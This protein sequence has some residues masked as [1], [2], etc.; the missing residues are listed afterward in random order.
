V[1]GYEPIAIGHD[2]YALQGAFD[3]VVLAVAAENGDVLWRAQLRNAEASAI[4]AAPGLLLTA[5]GGRVIAW[6]SLL[7]PGPRRIALARSTTDLRAGGHVH[8]AGVVGRK[9]RS[10]TRVRIERARLGKSRFRRAGRARLYRDG[11]FRGHRRLFV[12]SRFRS[13]V[14]GVKSRPVGVYA[15][16]RVRLRRARRA[17]ENIRVPIEVRSPKVSVV[18]HTFALYLQRA[19]SRRARLLDVGR[20]DGRRGLA[21]TELVFKPLRR[22]RRRD[23]LHFCIRGQ[24]GLGLGRPLPIVRHCGARRVRVGGA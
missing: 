9:L 17:G 7:R 21:K 22:V 15:W 20:L 8:F 13:R 11:G 19:G 23:R 2:I 3:R 5:S 16:P 18:G 12:N 24:V 1:P 14:G 4:G 10:N 6:E